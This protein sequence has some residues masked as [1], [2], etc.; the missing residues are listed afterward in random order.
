[1]IHNTP[2]KYDE[3]SCQQFHKLHY[4]ESKPTSIMI[5]HPGLLNA[6][7]KEYFKS[8][9]CDNSL[10]STWYW[11]FHPTLHKFSSES[12]RYQTVIIDNG[13]SWKEDVIL[14]LEQQKAHGLIRLNLPRDFQHLTGVIR[15]NPYRIDVQGSGFEG[16]RLNVLHLVHSFILLLGVFMLLP[17]TFPMELKNYVFWRKKIPNFR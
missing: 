4:V 2:F 10:S 5:M 1:M 14:A 11:E 16:T 13:I 9:H 15:Y 12:T 17:L 7:V 6:L 8:G 3:V